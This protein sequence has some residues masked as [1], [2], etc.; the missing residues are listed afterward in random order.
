MLGTKI[1]ISTETIEKLLVRKFQVCFVW[2]NL[3]FDGLYNAPLWSITGSCLACPR[4]FDSIYQTTSITCS[5]FHQQLLW[6]LRH[7]TF[8]RFSGM[9]YI[10]QLSVC[11]EFSSVALISSTS[12][13]EQWRMVIPGHTAAAHPAK[14]I[15]FCG[16]MVRA[17]VFSRTLCL[18][19][20]PKPSM[21]PLPWQGT[22]KSHSTFPS[23]NIMF[24]KNIFV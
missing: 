24:I 20:P 18:Q 1:W 17:R 21:S 8:T 4:I 22:L 7:L 16:L 19:V 12:V 6:G 11:Q 23:I 2:L 13:L 14:S 15:E 3:Y 9:E 10:V 5:S